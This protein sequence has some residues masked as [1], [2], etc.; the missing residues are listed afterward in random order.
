MKEHQLT[1]LIVIAIFAIAYA[2]YAHQKSSKLLAQ[3]TEELAITNSLAE[4]AAY[5]EIKT[6]ITKAEANED[7]ETAAELKKQLDKIVG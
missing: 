1:A 7:Y 5:L 3:S 6:R 2:I 4:V